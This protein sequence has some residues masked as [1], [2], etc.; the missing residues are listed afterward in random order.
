MREIHN[1]SDL[2]DAIGDLYRTIGLK[3]KEE[4]TNTITKLFKETHARLKLETM[5]ELSQCGC[6]VFEGE[7]DWLIVIG[8]FDAVCLRDRL[9]FPIAFLNTGNVDLRNVTYICNNMVFKNGGNVDLSSF[10]MQTYDRILFSNG[11]RATTKN[12]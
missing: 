8:G 12:F 3:S 10:D 6:S 4:L 11:G 2:R 7:D 5:G 9:D 1:F